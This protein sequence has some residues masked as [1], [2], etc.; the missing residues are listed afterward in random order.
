LPYALPDVVESKRAVGL[1]VALLVVGVLTVGASAVVFSDDSAEQHHADRDVELIETGNET[2]LWPYTS[3]GRAF[4]TRT[5]SI[6]VIVYGDAD[7]VSRALLTRTDAD[8]NE[9][10]RENEDL[11]PE[12]DPSASRPNGTGIAWENARGA[13]RYTYVAA[14]SDGTDAPGGY[15]TAES[16]Q[17]HDGDYLGTRYHVRLYEPLEDDQQWVAIQAHQEHW[18]W[19]GLRHSVDSNERAQQYVESDFMDQPFVQS[20]SREYYGT[21][22]PLDTDGWVTVIDLHGDAVRA[23]N[24]TERAQNGSAPA[25]WVG[26]TLA[27]IGVSSAVQSLAVAGLLVGLAG[28]LASAAGDPTVD[29]SHLARTREHLARIGETTDVRYLL[30]FGTTLSVL[31]SVRAAGIHLEQ[32][33]SVQPKLLVAVCY[34]LIPVG[35]PLCAYLPARD[36]DELGSFVVASTGVALG[37]TTDYALMGVGVLSVETLAH[38]LGVVLAVGLI[39]AG[40]GESITSDTDTS[41]LRLGALL[42]VAVVLAPLVRWL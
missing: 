11:E 16:A 39:A 13:T 2:A 1:V 37:I 4:A 40:A 8:W 24:A 26:A 14:D 35:V 3:R 33:L 12:A 17:F 28:L 5:L 42:W 41:T 36:L 27:G 25:V 19:F 21:S 22:D 7:T 29:R 30:L 18:D 32:T 23:Q 9:T 15:W 20:V 38:R 31:L 10:S 6:N 34:P